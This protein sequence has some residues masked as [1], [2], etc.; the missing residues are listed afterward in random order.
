MIRPSPPVKGASAVKGLIN[1][2]GRPS[3]ESA[4]IESAGTPP[5]ARAA[6]P[7]L[8]RQTSSTC[9]AGKMTTEPSLLSPRPLSTVENLLD[10]RMRTLSLVIIA[11]A[12]LFVAAYE[13]RDVMVPF[14]IA[15]ALKYILSP[16]IN[17]ISCRAGS[18]RRCRFRIPRWI[19]IF[20]ALAIAL[21]VV[22][23][24]GS[25][26]VHSIA[27]FSSRASMYNQQL[28]ELLDL[29]YVEI[30]DRTVARHQ[31]QGSFACPGTTR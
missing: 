18:C 4:G 31:Q 1:L 9:A 29:G 30:A 10:E 11:V 13:L 22:M 27:S 15:L 14:F 6:P 17:L 12:V 8:P 23:I 7:L 3:T 21:A 24:L 19:A 16:L 2:Y 5:A 25:L 20:L 26:V 28:F